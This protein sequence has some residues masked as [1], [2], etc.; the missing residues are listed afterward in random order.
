MQLQKKRGFTLIELLVVVLII[1]ILAAVALPQYRLA[2]AKS[3]YAKV[4]PLVESIAQAQEIYYLA[5]GEYST[6]L[7]ELDISFPEGRSRMGDTGFSYEDGLCN[8]TNGRTLCRVSLPG[9]SREGV[10]YSVTERHYEGDQ[11]PAGSRFCSALSTTSLGAKIC[12]LETGKQ[13]PDK[14]RA[15]WYDYY[16]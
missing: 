13:I 8:T 12:Q 15:G 5:N 7:D 16:Y 3:K 2:V 11:Y 1:G 9:G 10:M 6:N 4:K 14:P